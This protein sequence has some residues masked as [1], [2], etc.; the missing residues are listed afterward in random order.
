MDGVRYGD[1]GNVSRDHANGPGPTGRPVLSTLPYMCFVVVR[2]F[3]YASPP[4]F[5]ALPPLVF[6]RVLVTLQGSLKVYRIHYQCS[7][8]VHVTHLARGGKAQQEK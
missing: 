1:L 4:T 5:Q 6:H 7:G 8:A 2:A 3:P